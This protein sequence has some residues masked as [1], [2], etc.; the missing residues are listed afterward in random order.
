VSSRGSLPPLTAI[1]AFHAAG[2]AGSFKEAAR[3][4]SVT[5]SAISH[6][7]RALEHWLG[8]TLFERRT[9]EVVLTRQGRDFLKV[10]GRCFDLIQVAAVRLRERETGTITLRISTTQFFLSTWLIPRL[11]AFERDYPRIHLEIDSTNRLADFSREVV[12]LAIRN[13]RGGTPGLEHRKLLDLRPVPLCTARI[14]DQITQPADLAKQTLIHVSTRRDSWPRWLTAV[15]CAGLRARR[16]LT[17]DSALSALEAAARGRGIVLGM[18]PITWDAPAAAKL[19][20]ALPNRVE[21]TSSYYLVYRKSDLARRPVRECVHWL[22][23]ET[24]AY[25]NARA[26]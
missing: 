3:T 14:R 26:R 22:L 12:D 4:L 20:R 23:A 25:K 6:Q 10:V 18:D 13:A 21:G 24:A 8:R 1:R 19:V 7:V 2:T 16:D 11:E 9:R 15:G 5:P 17:F